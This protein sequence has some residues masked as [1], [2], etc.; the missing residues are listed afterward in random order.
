MQKS[1]IIGLIGLVF[2]L[3]G[4]IF[5]FASEKQEIKEEVNKHLK[6]KNL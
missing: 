1:T 4:T 3:A 2:S 5:G 6:E